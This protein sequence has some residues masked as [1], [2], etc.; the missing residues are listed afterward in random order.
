MR[1]TFLG[2]GD[3]F[4]S[5]GRFNTCFWVERNDGDFLID[6]G[7]SS[8][9]AMRKQNMDPNCIRTIFISHLHGDH[10]GGLPFFILDAQFYS[11]RTNPLTI[12]GPRGFTERVNA[13]ME[14]F[15]PGSSSTKQKF[16]FDVQEIDAGETRVING[17]SLTTTLVYHACGAPPLALRLTCDDKTI[18][19]SGDTEWT[20][21]L[22][23]IGQNADLFIAEALTFVRKIRF[24]L[25]YT[26]LKANLD[27][28][29]AKQVILTHLGPDMLAHVADVPETIAYDGLVVEF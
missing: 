3:A 9:I 22:I 21:A 25:D 13:A 7:A 6:C 19:Y 16:D 20:D 4:G 23:P 5:G 28:I 8:L 26:S 2:S 12:V 17:I 14:L 11:R 1:L 29:G 27:K 10:F 15:F 24:H 18:A